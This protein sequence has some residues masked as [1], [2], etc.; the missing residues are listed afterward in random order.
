VFKHPDA[1]GQYRTNIIVLVA[2]RKR[3]EFP[4][5]KQTA[6][7]MW[8]EFAPDCLIVEKKSSGA[9]LIYEMRAMGIPVQEFTPCK[10]SD[11][12]SRVNA[13]SDVFSSGFVWCPYTL[14]AD[15]LI[16]E[17]AAF[18]AGEH[19]DFV[20]SV[21]LALLRFRQGGFIRI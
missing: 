15:E 21:C 4:E 12:I 6:L 3:M 1:H 17:V 11:K 14:W 5:L 8:N 10:G 16:D 20:D 9:P 19:D 7:E 18:P 13:V 2:F